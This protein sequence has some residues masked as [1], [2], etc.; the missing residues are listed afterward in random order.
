MHIFREAGGQL[1]HFGAYRVR[2]IDGVSAGGLEDTDPDRILIVELGAQR[3]A[4]GTHLDARHVAQADQRAILRRF[5]NDI[6][7]LFF[8][9]QTAL[10]VNGD[11]EIALLRQRLGAKLSGRHLDVLLLHRRHHIR[12]RQTAGRDLIGIQPDAHRIFTG[13]KNLDLADAGQAR[14]LILHF[15]RGVVA[16]IQRVVLPVWRK[17]MHHQGQRRRLLLGGDPQTAYILRQARFGLRDA[18]LHLNL[19][20]I[21]VGTRAEGDGGDQHAVGAGDRFHV[22]H[23]FNAVDRFLQRRRHGLGNHFRVGAG[24]FRAHLDARRDDIRIFAHR[25]QWDSD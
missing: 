4:T 6:A 14:Q 24:I 17:Q 9:M 10:G 19:R 8:G 20:L 13:A 12:S 7:K 16:H 3:I 21:R 22:H 23:V 11:Q 18:V 25:Q 1:G 5:Q 2:Q 15:Q